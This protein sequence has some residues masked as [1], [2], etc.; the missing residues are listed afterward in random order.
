MKILEKAKIGNLTLNNKII[1]APM[2]TK[3]DG[4]GSF[5]ERDIAYFTERAKGGVG[6]IMTGR[7][8]TQDKY[9]MRTNH[10][11][12]KYHHVTKLSLMAEKI[13][14]YGSKLC[15]Q[16][17]P[18]VGRQAY[19]DPF[20]PPYSA[21]A[22]PAFW[23][24]NLMCRPYEKEQIEF[25]VQSVGWS[26]SL[27]KRAKAD[28][29]ELHAYGGYLL[30]QFHSPLWNKRTDEYGGDL[31][32]RL[33]FTL[34]IIKAIQKN[35][36]EDFPLIVKYTPYHGLPGGTELSEGIEMAKMLEAAG[37]HALHVDKG[38]HENWFDVISTIYEP[39]AHQLDIAAA[40]KAAVK[41]P[42]IS[43]GKLD[44][45]EVAERAVVEGKTDFIA[46][47]HQM[48]TDP[49]W[50]QKVKAGI[51]EYILPCIGCNECVH[52]SH[53]GR[54]QSCA[55]NPQGFREGDYPVLPANEKM[56][57]LIIGG[58]AA[59]MQ[60]A[61]TAAERGFDVELWEKDY[62]LGGQLLPA[63]APTFKQD[64]MRYCDY[65]VNKL[66][67]SKATVRLNKE[68]TSKEILSA[69]FDK[70]IIATGARPFI[71]PIK[72]IDGPNVKD[73][74]SV[75]M[76]NETTSKNVVVIGGGLV[77]VETA[78][79]AKETA[80]KVTVIEMREDIL[81]L[82]DHNDNNDQKI[83]KMITDSGV[84]T[85]CSARITEIGQDYIEFNKDNEIK[86]LDCDT[87]VLAAGFKSN[88]ELVQELEDVIEDLIVIGD[89]ISPRKIY[90]A[91][92]EGFHAARIINETTKVLLNK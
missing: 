66:S 45:P 10:L 54:Q 74:N 28:A 48:L 12:Y 8:G 14:L 17:G 38:A 4:D 91:V 73:A 64:I 44:K 81:L 82:A 49:Y 22:V 41:I 92:H 70:V 61:I 60:A 87:V 16:L 3:S 76:G 42:V 20:T 43:Q 36:G 18:G 5:S 55:V 29:V 7:V 6:M 67:R 53:Q 80:E 59:G 46:L 33:K 62:R 51:T 68:A 30:D 63:G 19:Q 27:A 88:N 77:G 37:V 72:G 79:F 34:D 2:G 11:L 21:S 90:T 32:G 85:I 25:L 9:E 69:N 40:V 24:P 84:E 56:S 1:M 23:F 50:V 52:S 71:P 31:K 89:A 65:L 15:V 47:G 83:R 39:D 78:V 13:H 58:G 26:A 57:V 86:R 75:L 35:C